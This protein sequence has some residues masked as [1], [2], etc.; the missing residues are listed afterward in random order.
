LSNHPTLASNQ[1][2]P[3]EFNDK[4]TI[5]D[6]FEINTRGML[7]VEDV[8]YRIAKNGGAALFIDYGDL[9]PYGNSLQAVYDHK[10]VSPLSM[11]GNVDL[12]SLIDFKSMMNS[13]ERLKK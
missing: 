5:G 2:L 12:T 4:A 8:S 3:K 9:K 6:R 10:Y 13:V 7:A 11:P 1:F